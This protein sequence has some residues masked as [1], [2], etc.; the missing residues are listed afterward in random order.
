MGVYDDIKS[1][2][3]K[4]LKLFAIV[5]IIYFGMVIVGAVIALAYPDLQLSMIK[6]AGQSFGSGGLL[7]GVGDAYSAGNIPMAALLTFVTN[8]FLGTLIQIV[9]PS[10]IIPFWALLMGAFRALL[11]GVMLVIPVPG[12]LPLERLAPHYLTI[13]LEGEAYVVA[14]FACTRGLFALMDPKSFGTDSR[15]RAYWLSI[16]DNGK[17]LLVVIALLAVAAAYEAWEVTFFAGLAGSVAAGGQ[18]G[19]YDQEFGPDSGYS[20]WTQNIP[21]NKLAGLSFDIGGGK[22]ARAMIV[23]NG[24]P[25]DVLIMDRGNFSIFNATPEGGG[26]GAYVIKK[27]VTNETFDFIPPKD[28]TYWFVTRN[29]GDK[30]VGIHVK[31]RYER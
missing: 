10:L 3:K 22:L 18:F 12:V 27:N 17:L 14:I 24:T 31:F 19:F 26:W 11:W 9:I 23:T 28:Y 15:M 4:D 21:A 16:K 8:F 29:T 6:A 30:D 5:N 13:L 20:N 25:V 1:I 7:G 2:F